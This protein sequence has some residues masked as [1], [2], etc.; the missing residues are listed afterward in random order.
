[1]EGPAAHGPST[2][3]ASGR[4]LASPPSLKYFPLGPVGCRESETAPSRPKW[5]PL[6]VSLSTTAKLG[7]NANS[8]SAEIVRLLLTAHHRLGVCVGGTTKV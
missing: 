6:G 1:M 8:H 4:S 2:G 7:E 5:K 3:Q